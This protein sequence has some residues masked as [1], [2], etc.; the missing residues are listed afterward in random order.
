MYTRSNHLRGVVGYML[1]LP[2]GRRLSR[3]V[4]PDNKGVILLNELVR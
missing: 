2:Q 1:G 4:T 3:R